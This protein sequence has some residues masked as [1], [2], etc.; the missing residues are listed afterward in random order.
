MQ[1]CERLLLGGT[2]CHEAAEL[3]P[4]EASLQPDQGSVNDSKHNLVEHWGNHRRHKEN[5]G[6]STT[7]TDKTSNSL[8]SSILP[9]NTK[10]LFDE[11][12][13]KLYQ[14]EEDTSRPEQYKVRP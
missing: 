5:T 2:E 9:I 10:D 7:E 11:T 8:E 3:G 6:D 14:K 12:R 13:T 1:R 4:L